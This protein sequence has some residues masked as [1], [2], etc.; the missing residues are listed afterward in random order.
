MRRY[1]RCNFLFKPCY[2]YKRVIYRRSTGS[3]WS[4]SLRWTRLKALLIYTHYSALNITKF[5][6]FIY[7][8]GNEFTTLAGVEFLWS[9]DNADKRIPDSKAP[10]DVLRFM[11]Y[12]ESQYETPPTIAALDAIGKKGHVVL[13]EGI[14]TGTAKVWKYTYNYYLFCINW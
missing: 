12:Q 4:T 14:K 2:N 9:I 13:L 3:V 7:Y 10:N 1:C 8:I 5:F 11:T 6:I